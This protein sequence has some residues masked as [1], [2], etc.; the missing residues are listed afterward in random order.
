[1][2]VTKRRVLVRVD[3]SPKIGG[4]HLARCLALAHA[5]E[6]VGYTP[7]FACRAGSLDTLPELLA[8][9]STT[10]ELKSTDEIDQIVQRWAGTFQFVVVDHYGLDASFERR[11]S[12]IAERVVAIDDAPNR[13]HTCDTLLD[14]THGRKSYEYESL[15]PS[16]CQLL[17]GSRFALLRAEF[18][19]KRAAALERRRRE[20]RC[21][22]ILVALGASDT[23]DSTVSAL[24]AITEAEVAPSVIVDIA[25][26]AGVSRLDLVRTAAER[27][28]CSYALHVGTQDMA[29]LMVHADVAIGAAGSSAWERCCLGL[30]TI[31]MVIA[32]N[33]ATIADRLDR[34]GAAISTGLFARGGRERVVR[35]ITSL[36]NDSQRRLE[37][38]D[39]AAGICDGD[40]AKRTV[41]ALLGNIAVN[42]VANGRKD[43]LLTTQVSHD[44][45]RR[46]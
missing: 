11:L 42:R 36:M 10:L 25:L 35:A 1:M 37:I 22:R 34:A 14:Q 19:N 24:E 30:P 32:D 26:G 8:V 31:M 4:G 40:G 5:F 18:S 9:G 41:E 2:T 38:T 12:E 17:V 44:E 45:F 43:R 23:A 27:L 16:G 13:S 46:S 29:E 39:A 3:A 15:V 33:Q 7:H 6:L 20:P 21:E 28:P